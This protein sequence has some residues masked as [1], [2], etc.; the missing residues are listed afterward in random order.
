MCRGYSR[1]YG[2]SLEREA[3]S[4]TAYTA[5]SDVQR[6]QQRI[7]V[8]PREAYSYTAYTAY[9][10]VQRIQQRIRV[11]PRERSVQLYSSSPNIACSSDN[12]YRDSHIYAQLYEQ[13][14]HAECHRFLDT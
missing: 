7:R 1:G 14:A 8:E 10:D 9:S 4:Y 6:I 13:E 12:G 2:W 5:Y 3:Y 11:E